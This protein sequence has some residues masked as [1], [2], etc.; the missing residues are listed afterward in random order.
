MS[1]YIDQTNIVNQNILESA[2]DIIICTICT[3]VVIN[4]LQ[5]SECD[6]CFCSTCIQKWNE[7]SVTCPFKCDFFSVKEPSRIIKNIFAK[8]IFTCP[9]GC[10]THASYNDLHEHL[11]QCSNEKGPCPVCGSVVQR[12]GM[13]NEFDQLKK[14]NEDLRKKISE[15]ESALLQRQTVVIKSSNSS[16]N[17]KKSSNKNLSNIPIDNMESFNLDIKF[18]KSFEIKKNSNLYDIHHQKSKVKYIFK[19]CVNLYDCIKC[20][21]DK[22]QHKAET[23]IGLVCTRCEYNS[24]NVNEANCLRCGS[25]FIKEEQLKIEA[26]KFKTNTKRNGDSKQIKLQ[27]QLDAFEI[28]SDKSD[29][30]PIILYRTKNKIGTHSVNREVL[31]PFSSKYKNPTTK[32]LNKLNINK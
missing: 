6:N 26:I 28:K 24:F 27:A 1:I 22:E 11:S 30:Q 13:I 21:N 23:P 3:G 15:L 32:S 29:E 31:R 10:S 18:N 7:K 25:K 16:N 20:H 14:E 17:I 8:I 19:C 12:S 9:K 2:H 4:P 5:C